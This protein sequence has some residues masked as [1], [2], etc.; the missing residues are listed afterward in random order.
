MTNNKQIIPYT[1]TEKEGNLINNTNKQTLCVEKLYQV[2]VHG[3]KD[4]SDTN[5]ECNVWPTII[6]SEVMPELQ[7]W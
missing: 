1:I 2:Y 6:K 5:F 7:N 4:L 3:Q